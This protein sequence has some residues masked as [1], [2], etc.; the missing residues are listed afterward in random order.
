MISI[1]S[2]TMDQN[3][4]DPYYL[5][6]G[7]SAPPKYDRLAKLAIKTNAVQS[8]VTDRAKTQ[9]AANQVRPCHR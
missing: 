6:N 3:N 7:R 8:S 9:A 1:K 2:K 5:M 4:G